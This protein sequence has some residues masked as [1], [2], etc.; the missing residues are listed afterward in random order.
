[1]RIAVLLDAL[2]IFRSGVHGSDA[3]GYLYNNSKVLWFMQTTSFAALNITCSHISSILANLLSAVVTIKQSHVVLKST[4]KGLS[5]IVN[6]F[7]LMV[8][9]VVGFA[10][11]VFFI[12]ESNGKL[13]NQLLAASICFTLSLLVVSSFAF[14]FNFARVFKMADGFK[15]LI[16]VG[17]VFQVVRL[18]FDIVLLTGGLKLLRMRSC[19]RNEVVWPL[20]MVTFEVLC[21]LIPLSCFT[22]F[23]S[24][25][26]SL[27]SQT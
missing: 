16:E 11:Q 14:L 15:R 3:G 18:L 1:V 24:D 17:C 12:K 23:F 10:E 27:S 22:A 4:V 5:I 8:T 6:I 9:V 21:N 26:L 7:I 13:T 2:G 19:S 20:V 25:K